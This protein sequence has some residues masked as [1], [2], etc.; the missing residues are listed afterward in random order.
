MLATLLFDED[1]FWEV[2][3]GV[4]NP[5]KIDVAIVHDNGKGDW[6]IFENDEAVFDIFDNAE[7]SRVLSSYIIKINNVRLMFTEETFDAILS[8]VKKVYN[9]E[10]PACGKN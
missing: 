7:Y 1:T 4:R 8:D 10:V 3:R 5:D 2:S 6:E 9:K